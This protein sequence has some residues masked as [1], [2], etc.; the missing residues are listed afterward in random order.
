[1][2]KLARLPV[3]R[4]LARRRAARRLTVEALLAAEQ[5]GY[6]RAMAEKRHLVLV[7]S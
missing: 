1:M 2:H 6:D 4:G 3:L 7:T 5:R